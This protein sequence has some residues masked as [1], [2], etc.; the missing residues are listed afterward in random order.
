MNLKQ[1]M[2]TSSLIHTLSFHSFPQ[3][4]HSILTVSV[5]VKESIFKKS[6][7]NVLSVNLLEEGRHVSR[8]TATEDRER[9]LHC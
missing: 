8:G 6:L 7:S 1:T 9:E 4:T 2:Y 3:P 5:A